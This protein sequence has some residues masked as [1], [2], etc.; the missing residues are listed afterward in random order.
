MKLAFFNE[1]LLH[2]KIFTLGV[3]ADT[4][5]PDRANYLHPGL[6]PALRSA[7]VDA[8]FHLCDICVPSVLSELE[9]VAP[10]TAVRG[11]RDWLFRR[12]LSW[13]EVFEI[14][15]L[16]VGLVH[17]HGGWLEY[18][19][20]KWYFYRDGYRLERYQKLLLKKIPEANII[21][22]GHTHCPENI[23]YKGRLFF[24]PGSASIESQR[25]ENP[26]IGLLSFYSNNRVFGKIIKLKGFILKNK[27]WIS[28]KNN[29]RI[30]I[31]N[32]AGS[33]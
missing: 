28:K 12:K 20:D 15:G 26:T 31:R 29:C 13:F 5:I 8:I 14:A 30:W 2:H 9:N 4:H 7:K 24:N 21:I 22:F 1:P 17:G 27:H 25:G 16:H 32:N 33:C 18:L 19:W 23:W 3:V 6:G 10:T 11:N